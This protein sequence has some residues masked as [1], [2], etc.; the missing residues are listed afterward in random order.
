MGV[1]KKK[2][3]QKGNEIINGLQLWNKISLFFA[4][5]HHN[6]SFFQ[7]VIIF[8]DVFRR[9]IIFQ[10]LYTGILYQI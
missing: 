3:K 8:L 1:I 6:I 9:R 4:S 2:V 10:L 5:E 7:F